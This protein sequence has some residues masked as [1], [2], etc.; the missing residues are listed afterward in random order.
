MPQT[1][2]AILSMMV[3]SLFAYNQHRSALSMRLE[4]INQD[5]ELRSTNVAV[6]LM[7]EIGSMAFDD[8]TKDGPIT[9]VSDL[10]FRTNGEQSDSEA[11]GA[12]DI[13]DYDG[14]TIERTREREGYTLRFTAD[15]EVDYVTDSGYSTAGTPSKLKKVTLSVVSQDI[16][17]A[18]TVRISQIFSCG[19]RCDW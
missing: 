11:G 3:A 13:D 9:T 16:S 1:M 8:A 6:D 18:D 19:A 17:F 7:E 5:M 14:A 15:A 2:I 10:T 4:M 12:D